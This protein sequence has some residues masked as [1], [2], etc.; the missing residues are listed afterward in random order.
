MFQGST[1]HLELTDIVLCLFCFLGLWLVP[2][3]P[4][5]FGCRSYLIRR[6]NSF[7]LVAPEPMCYIDNNKLAVAHQPCCV[8]T[9]RHAAHRM[10]RTGVQHRAA[11]I[12][13][14]AQHSVRCCFTH[15]SHVTLHASLNEPPSMAQANGWL[16]NNFVRTSQC[17]R[18]DPAAHTSCQVLPLC[19]IAHSRKH[20]AAWCMQRST[21]QLCPASCQA[22]CSST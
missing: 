20:P 10:S 4:V 16:I 15:A 18:R 3:S 13:K 5:R 7:M 12:F 21:R 22:A 14:L 17:P 8:M 9:S 19:S 11:R 2:S 6:I 1:G